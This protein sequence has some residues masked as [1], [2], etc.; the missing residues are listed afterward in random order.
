MDNLREKLETFLYNLNLQ[1]DDLERLQAGQHIQVFFDTGH[2][3]SAIIGLH[4]FYTQASGF[5]RSKFE[6]PTALVTSLAAANWLGEIHLLPPHQAE[7]WRKWKLGFDVDSTKRPE[8]LAKR[9]LRDVGY[10][11]NNWTTKRSVA[12]LS[13]Q[14]IRRMIIKNAASAPT[15]FK[16]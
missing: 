14:Q 16:A 4:D 1:I 8:V 11:D 12:L 3:V 13:D 10:T 7:F 9:F 6:S 5:R 15:F 2:L